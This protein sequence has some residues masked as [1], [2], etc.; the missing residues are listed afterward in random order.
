MGGGWGV[1]VGVE[2]E[3]SINVGA[4]RFSFYPNHFLLH[5]LGDYKKG[6][7][8]KNV[9]GRRSCQN[10]DKADSSPPPPVTSRLH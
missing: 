8:V 2:L 3:K 10:P 6:L 5:V 1:G 9:Y 4:V 7:P